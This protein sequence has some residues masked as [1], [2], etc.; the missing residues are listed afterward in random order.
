[1]NL[2]LEILRHCEA[3]AIAVA[4][5]TVVILAPSLAETASRGG[6]ARI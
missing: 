2:K 5:Y 3:I 1:M 6:K 4:I